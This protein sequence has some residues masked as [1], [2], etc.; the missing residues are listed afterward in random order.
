M[1]LCSCAICHTKG[2]SLNG[3]Q[4]IILIFFLI[5]FVISYSWLGHR[6]S[7]ILCKSKYNKT[8]P[9]PRNSGDRIKEPWPSKLHISL[10]DKL[11]WKLKEE[12]IFIFEL[13]NCG[14]SEWHRESQ[15]DCVVTVTTL[16]D[17]CPGEHFPKISFL[18]PN[19]DSDSFN[20][21]RVLWR[22]G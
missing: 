7:S 12:G 20:F 8:F 17:R 9:P 22:S 11:Y 21:V 3:I 13:L 5:L 10:G 16:Q 19:E 18:Q 15:V 6:L 1:H 14:T 2:C 4:S